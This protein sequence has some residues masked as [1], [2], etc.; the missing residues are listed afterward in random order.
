MED[1]NNS[2]DETHIHLLHI[3]ANDQ[4]SIK[5][6]LN[7]LCFFY[8][9]EKTNS[10]DEERK[11]FNKLACIRPENI[12]D[13]IIADLRS[14][15]PIEQEQKESLFALM[16]HHRRPIISIAKNETFIC[17]DTDPNLLHITIPTSQMEKHTMQ[18]KDAIANYW[19]N[20]PTQSAII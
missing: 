13:I 19:F 3:T 5:L 14:S 17:N 12:F 10:K 8:T 7:K 6:L 20:T 1:Q 16:R 2:L 11:L 9:I 18:I 15:S 4:N